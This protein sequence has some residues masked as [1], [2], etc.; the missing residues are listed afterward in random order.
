M[1]RVRFL[2]ALVGVVLFFAIFLQ[3]WRGL[4][5]GRARWA[6]AEI[7]RDWGES[8]GLIR[9]REEMFTKRRAYPLQHIPAGARMK[10]LRQL[11]SLEQQRQDRALGSQPGAS[12]VSTVRSSAGHAAAPFAAA[13]LS[14]T[15]WTQIGP[16]ATEAPYA[17]NPSSGRVT[18]LAVDPT[19]SNTVYLG[20]AEGGVWKTTDGGQH[21]TPLT[22]DQASL[23]IGSLAI[24]PTNPSVIYAG[25]GEEDTAFDAYYGAGVLKSSDG[26]STWTQIPGPFSGA[27]GSLSP[28]CGGATIGS[29]AVDPANSQVLLAGAA[30]FC[31]SSSPSGIYR[32]TDG[33][34]TW[35]NVLPGGFGSAALFDSAGLTAYAALSYGGNVNGI[36]KST[37]GGKTWVKL[38]GGLPTSN[39][40]K[41]ALG[42]DSSSSNTVYAGIAD[43]SDQ[44]KTLLGVFKTVDG[45][46]TWTQ[47]T[48]APQYCSPA[49]GTH[50]CYFD[51][52]V[53]VAPNNPN[54]VLLGGSEIISGNGY[55]G[56]IFLS[57]DG[58]MTWSDITNDSNGAGVHPDA[59]AIAFSADGG[60]VYVGT[61]GGASSAPLGSS[62]VGAWSNLNNNLALT[63]FYP[64]MSIIPVDPNYAFAGSQDNGTQEYEGGLLWYYITCGDGAQTAYNYSDL[65]TL[66]VGCIYEPPNTDPYLLRLTASPASG[67][68]VENGINGGDPGWPIPP[69]TMDPSSPST[70]YFATNRVYQ[71]T[72][73]GDSW[74]PISDDL[75]RGSGSMLSTV[76]S[77]AV[78]P[79]DTGTVYAG[80][81]DGLLWVTNGAKTSATPVWTSI[82]DG[83]PNRSVTAVAVDP[84][85]A[86]VVYATFSGF[87]GFGDSLGHVF[88]SDN[89]GTSWN[90]IS[91]TLPNVPVNDI[92]VDPDVAN[93]VYVGTDIGVFEGTNPGPA[94]QWT[95]LGTGLP[96]VVIMSLKMYR[97]GR[98]LRA[99]TYG[100]SVWDILLPPPAGPDAAL[101][102]PILS[103]SSQYEGAASAAQAV[104]LANNSSTALAISSIAASG[105]YAETDDCGSSLA[106]G[107]SCTISVTF[108]PTA[109]GSRTGLVT[110]SDNAASG[111]SQTVQL[112]GFG[113]GSAAFSLA[114][115]SG[116]SSTAT[117]SAGGMAGYS[118]TLTP[119]GGFNQ[120]VALGCSG[121][122]SLAACT[123]SPSSVTLDGTD[124]EN[125][126]VSVSTTA[127]AELPPGSF[128]RGPGGW[129]AALWL[130][131]I[132]LALLLRGC[133]LINKE[134]SASTGRALQRA[135][136]LIP[137]AA[138]VLT[139]LCVSCGG[140]GSSSGGGAHSPG[141]PAG[142]YTLI[143]TATSGSLSQKTNLTLIVQ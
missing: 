98:I 130:G 62:G 46:A 134:S 12:S 119:S 48:S 77:V 8:G 54:I 2:A 66:Y 15:Q 131:A 59:H 133:K 94:W 141:T 67:K 78:A 95:P 17:F 53:A 36:Y 124:P 85:D 79:S 117:V 81:N 19:N 41:I 103:F 93:S 71:T 115:A 84:A 118:L 33:G 122:P 101:S 39:V 92:V 110:I 23:A 113:F 38:A 32:S 52:V 14:A 47:L 76:S 31:G 30:F 13:A 142:T 107:A 87:S 140:G 99:A 7:G 22:D 18:A 123:V 20:G 116:G 73:A 1:A 6:G 106:G 10:A 138:L 136:A 28:Y 72:S 43:D 129:P 64:G 24:D 96:N 44:S 102:T 29:L 25:T 111:S 16:A 137:F 112:T 120:T 57:L 108:T 3:P 100:R 82:A 128:P 61:D 86:Q 121:A 89:G 105:D 9:L 127:P 74:T 21:W 63:Q 55:T 56:T 35:T 109:S 45:G 80:T 97:A 132:A 88:R 70:L 126:S 26:G 5:Q 34:A 68:V 51:N 125:V 40:G 83:T 143:V 104:V 42:L 27:T 135:R 50:Q 49:S 139:A 91:G 114:V 58:G 37:D 69:L 11:R 65:N 4:C 90:D 60:T 75:T